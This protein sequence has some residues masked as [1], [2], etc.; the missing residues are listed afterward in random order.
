MIP[1]PILVDKTKKHW[2]YQQNPIYRV[3]EP[4][5]KLKANLRCFYAIAWSA[6][7][8]RPFQRSWGISTPD[9]IISVRGMT[10]RAYQGPKK[11]E[12]HPQICLRFLLRYANSKSHFFETQRSGKSRFSSHGGSKKIFCITARFNTIYFNMSLCSAGY[13]CSYGANGTISW[14]NHLKFEGFW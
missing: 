13:Y 6:E 7:P 4:R 10:P 9:P 5:Q 8:R 2:Q 11:I 3:G 14:R 12:K 1:N